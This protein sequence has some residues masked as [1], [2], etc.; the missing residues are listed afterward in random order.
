VP[1]QSV[2]PAS[3]APAI[4]G[5]GLTV[6]VRGLQV[7]A[8]IGVYDHERGGVQPVVVDVELELD[9][10][11]VEHLRDTINYERI[12]QAAHDVAASGHIE[13]V[14]QFADRV[15]RACLGDPR[16]RAARVRVEKPAI[17][18]GAQGAGCEIR[19]AR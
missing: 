10:R 14:E 11:P 12:A 19:L 3:I 5:E 4:R 9:P 8:R 13:L 7:Q 16:V 18:P 1:Q 2:Q 15:G 6:F 17:L